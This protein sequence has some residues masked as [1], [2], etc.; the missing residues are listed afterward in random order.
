MAPS[1]ALGVL[2]KLPQELRRQVF[3]TY[4]DEATIENRG[5]SVSWDYPWMD[6]PDDCIPSRWVNEDSTSLLQTSSAIHAE[7]ANVESRSNLRLNI[8]PTDYR[9]PP[10]KLAARVTSIYATHERAVDYSFLRIDDFPS[11]KHIHSVD[12][13][14]HMTRAI[15]ANTAV[16]EDEIINKAL[17]G[18]QDAD[19][20]DNLRSYSNLAKLLERKTINSGRGNRHL[21]HSR[22][23]CHHIEATF[24]CVSGLLDPKRDM[25]SNTLQVINPSLTCCSMSLSTSNRE[26]GESFSG[27]WT[28]P[29]WSSAKMAFHT[30]MPRH[31]G[32]V[33]DKHVSCFPLEDQCPGR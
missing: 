9:P 12:N 10:P 18:G 32:R 15:V 4:F 13:T 21:V 3:E 7:A 28:T 17:T 23:P 14:M 19:I 22:L 20:I 27:A 25:V 11:L 2:G 8:K 26:S 1:S 33:I 6:T 24:E 29:V 31:G 16:R 30:T 5:P